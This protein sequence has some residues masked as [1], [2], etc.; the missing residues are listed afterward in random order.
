MKIFI[1]NI[2]IGGPSLAAKQRRA[3]IGLERLCTLSVR[4]W[5]C[6]SSVAPR[7]LRTISNSHTK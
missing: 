2:I 6:V 1:L 5:K 4:N 3:S 7:T